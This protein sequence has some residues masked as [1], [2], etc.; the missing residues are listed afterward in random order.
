MRGSTTSAGCG[1]AALAASDVRVGPEPSRWVEMLVAAG[2][3]INPG[4]QPSGARAEA[5]ADCRGRRSVPLAPAG[6]SGRSRL[7]AACPPGFHSARTELTGPGTEFGETAGRGRRAVGPS[8]VPATLP[9]AWGWAWRSVAGS[10]NRDGRGTRGSSSSSSAT[11]RSCFSCRGRSLCPSCEKKRQLLWAGW[12]C[13]EVLAKVAHRHVVLKIP[14]RQVDPL[15]C[16]ARR[17]TNCSLE[18]VARRCCGRRS[19]GRS[20]TTSV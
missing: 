13:E 20:L 2:R 15:A 7:G 6:A 16:R 19:Y 17:R 11:S 4:M 8:F 12:L 18:P 10:T 5:S 14:V 3:K 9:P 1:G